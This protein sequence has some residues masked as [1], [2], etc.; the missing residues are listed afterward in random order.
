[1]SRA[2]VHIDINTFYVS[3][4]RQ[5]NSELNGIPLIIGRCQRGVVG[6]SS[7]EAQR[8]GARS[9]MPI[10]MA[11]KLCPQAKIIKGDMELYCRAPLVQCL[12]R[13]VYRPAQY[14][15]ISDHEPARPLPTAA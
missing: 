13:A 2:I 3:C 11:M 12:P 8:F 10:H 6:L 1:M 15:G 7:Y 14:Q 4:E 5:T 9:A